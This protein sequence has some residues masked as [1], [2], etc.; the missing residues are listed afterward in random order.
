MVSKH[1]TMSDK[2]LFVER[3]KGRSTL[4]RVAIFRVNDKL[5]F[6]GHV[7]ARIEQFMRSLFRRQSDLSCDWLSSGYF[8]KESDMKR[9]LLTTI[10]MTIVIATAGV[11][12]ASEITIT[13]KLQKTV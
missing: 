12:Q 6:I 13:G 1:G 2:L 9:L 4:F 10:A 3:D 7:R 5:K 8:Y 11:I